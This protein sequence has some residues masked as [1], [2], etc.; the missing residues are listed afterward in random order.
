MLVSTK[1]ILGRARHGGYAVGHFNVSNMEVLQGVVRAA[2]KQRSPVILATTEGALQYA[3]MDYLLCLACTAARLNK[4]PIALHLDHGQDLKNIKKAIKLGYSSVMLD[5]S[6]ED[7]ETNVKLTKR[8]VGWAHE[9]GVSVEAELGTIGGVEDLVVTRK[10]VYTDPERAREFVART[11][12]DFLA[13]AIGTSHG[14]FKF[15]GRGCLRQDILKKIKSVTGVPLVLHGASAVPA[16]V[17]REAE[18]YG[19]KLSGVYGVPPSQ[20]RLAI[21]N[22]ITKINTDTDLRLAFDAG[23]R[24]FLKEHPEDF[25]PRHILGAARDSIQ[26]VAEQRM[27]LFGSSGKA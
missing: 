7:F 10:I 19:A 3:G 15:S 13:V 20:I 17:V 2:V 22:G 12:C 1:R 23:V 14:A 5:K 11:G 24:R 18:M 4:V 6:H 16:A 27:K 26:K 21:R 25:D 9:R 8:V